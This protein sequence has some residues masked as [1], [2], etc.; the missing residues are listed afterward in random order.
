M[1]TDRLPAV[2]GIEGRSLKTILK[3]MQHIM[4]NPVNYRSILEDEILNFQDVHHDE[5]RFL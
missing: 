5:I 1:D 2:L 4:C 3:L